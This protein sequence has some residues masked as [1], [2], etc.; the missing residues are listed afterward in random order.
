MLMR[1]HFGLV[2]GHKYAH[3]RTLG[4]LG[5]VLESPEEEMIQ[6]SDS[7]IMGHPETAGTRTTESDSEESGSESSVDYEVDYWG[8]D[9]GE[10]DDNDDEEAAEHSEMY[11]V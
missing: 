9:D 11:G 4:S 8:Y 10:G 7:V 6:D 5:T 3:G 2:V 1:Y